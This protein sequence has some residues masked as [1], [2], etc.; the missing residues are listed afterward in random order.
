MTS[1][2]NQEITMPENADTSY[3][4]AYCK[5]LLQGSQ[6]HC[7]GANWCEFVHVLFSA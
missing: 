1:V 5:L 6:A 3:Y 2:Q 4:R 7:I